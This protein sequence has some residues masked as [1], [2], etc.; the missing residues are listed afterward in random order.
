VGRALFPPN[1]SKLIVD[2]VRRDLPYYEPAIRPEFIAGMSQFCRK[3]GILKSD[4]Q[5]DRV[6]AGVAR[7]LWET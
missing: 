2:L 1:E 3:C 4:L 5:Y 6:V 7:A